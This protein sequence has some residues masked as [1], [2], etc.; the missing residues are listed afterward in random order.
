MTHRETKPLTSD[1]DSRSTLL[2][3]DLEWTCW[4]ETPPKG[5]RPEIIEV[6]VV[7]MDLTTLSL[8]REQ[9]H[10][11]RPRRWEISEKCTALTGITPEDVRTGR[12]LDQ[13]VALIAQQFDPLPKVCCAWGDDV[14]ILAAKCSAVGIE[15][16]FRRS[17]DLSRILQQLL[18]APGQMSLCAAME[19]F[20]LKF[21]GVPHGALPDARNT[22]SP[23]CCHS[24]QTARYTRAADY[25]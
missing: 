1:Y 9:A 17:V 25:E 16:P 18:G 2:Y 11:V 22:A 5:L 6:G 13:I 21:D 10:F 19:F 12:P 24:A 15:P 20:G 23:A 4:N 7:E 14:A 8:I 3:L